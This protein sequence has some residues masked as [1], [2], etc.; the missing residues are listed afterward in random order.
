MPFQYFR[1]WGQMFQRANTHFLEQKWK[2]SEIQLN[3]PHSMQDPF[4]WQSVGK[5]LLTCY[6]TLHLQSNYLNAGMSLDLW[7]RSILRRQC[8][9]WNNCVSLI[10]T[11]LN[12]QYPISTVLLFCR[13][14][15]D[16][17]VRIQHQQY[18][19][20]QACISFWEKNSKC[21]FYRQMNLR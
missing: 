15:A 11:S 9:L 16:T 6:I 13:A 3:A 1:L 8:F 14:L 17:F 10:Y 12:L 20:N 19:C 4:C 5:L 7:C 21:M 18:V 2:L